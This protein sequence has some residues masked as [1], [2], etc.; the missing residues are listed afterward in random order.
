M[1]KAGTSESAASDFGKA[2][3]KDV[4]A[5]MCSLI[6][7]DGVDGAD[8]ACG[9][10][11]K[12]HLRLLC[13]GTCH[14]F[15]E[16]SPSKA[17][18]D[19]MVNATLKHVNTQ[20]KLG[21]EQP[22]P[23]AGVSPVGGGGKAALLYQWGTPNDASEARVADRSTTEKL[24]NKKTCAILAWSSGDCATSRP[25]APSLTHPCSS[26]AAA[27]PACYSRSR[28]R[29]GA[30]DRT[31]RIQALLKKRLGETREPP[32]LTP[33]ELQCLLD[34]GEKHVEDVCAWFRSAS[35]A[36]PSARRRG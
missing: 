10:R 31:E 17:Q 11:T 35:R 9:G 15:F 34:L 12:G 27:R 24:T 23:A 18:L 26:V 20:L 16:L 8:S 13:V 4:V 22:Q 2:Q 19:S 36:F 14:T 21:D 6:R 5:F 3:S 30:C 32:N 29:R 7:T 25:A 28:R 1:G 33:E